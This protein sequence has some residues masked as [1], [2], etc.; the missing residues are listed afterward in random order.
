R[1][2]SYSGIAKLALR[3]ALAAPAFRLVLSWSGNEYLGP[4]TLLPSRADALGL[5][6]L[7]AAACRNRVAWDWLRSH[8]AHLY[9]VFWVLGCGLAFLTVQRRYIYV[10]GITWIAAF[11]ASL[12][13]LVVVDPGR[14]EIIVFRSELLRGL[15]TVAY[16][17]YLFHQG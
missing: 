6:V 3:A 11:Y 10:F 5:G 14:L 4:F 7:I 9:R 12:L 17:V 13:L 16:G 2:I 1:R 8:R 15:G